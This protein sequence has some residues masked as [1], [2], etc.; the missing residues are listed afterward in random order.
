[1]KWTVKLVAETAPGAITEYDLLTL[2]RPNQL[3]LARLGLSIEEA[4]RLL[5]ALQNR[6]VP[7]QVERHGQFCPNCPR[8]GRAFRGRG[9]YPVT[10]RSLF[11]DV[12]VR[13]RRLRMCP[14]QG[15]QRQSF[16]TVFT[17]KHP[18]APE[19]NF[20]TAKLA[21]LLPFGKVTKIGRASCRERVEN[22]WV[23]EGLN[24]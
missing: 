5:A 8:C 20:L 1:M 11:G 24:Y 13:V 22:A 12:P 19:L 16:S 3:S 23:D 14:C 21:A 9:S 7:A 17:S 2:E 10:F 18:V 4:K 15:S 6:L